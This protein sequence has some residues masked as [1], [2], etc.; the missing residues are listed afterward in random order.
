M[1]NWW[2][3]EDA[4]KTRIMQNTENRNDEMKNKYGRR[5]GRMKRDNEDGKYEENGREKGIAE[6]KKE[7]TLHSS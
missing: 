4:T 5:K 3:V 6:P 2:G 7:G 1:G